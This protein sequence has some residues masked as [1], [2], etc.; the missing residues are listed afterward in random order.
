MD[1]TELSWTSIGLSSDG[2]PASDARMFRACKFGRFL[3]FTIDWK[4]IWLSVL[5]PKFEHHEGRGSPVPSRSQHGD[6]LEECQS[7]K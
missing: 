4:M 2:R 3:N 7:T 1:E 6:G 5:D